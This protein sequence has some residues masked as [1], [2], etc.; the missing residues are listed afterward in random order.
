MEP[1]RPTLYYCPLEAYKERYTMQLSAPEWGW[2]ERNWKACGIPYVRVEGDRPHEPQNIN[3]GVALDAVGR[4]KMCFA[5]VTKLLELLPGMK[6]DDVI[7]FDDF[8]HPGMEAIAYAAQVMGRPVPKMYANLW[9]QSVD[10]FDFTYP[11]RQWMRHY[12]RGNAAVLSG[13]FVACPSLKDKVVFGGIAG[14]DDVHA[15]GHPF[16]SDE[17]KSRMTFDAPREDKVVFSSRWDAEKNPLFFLCVVDEVLRRRPNTRFVVCSSHRTLRSNR[18]HLLRHLQRAIAKHKGKLLLK[19]GLTKEQYYA[20]LTTAKIQ[21]NTADQ[22]WISYVLLE[23]SCAGCYP[24][25]PYFRSFPEVFDFGPEYMYQRLHTD[26][27]ADMVCGVLDSDV[28]LWTDGAISGRAWIHERFDST[29]ER[30]AIIMG[31]IEGEVN[32]PF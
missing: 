20:E 11:M 6:F 22:D 14:P 12:E 2:L 30:M 28:D 16:S 4:T 31:L 32:E 23:A 21:I 19:E 13:I 26:N 10:E 18:E 27:A 3:T 8:W 24:V 7:Y 5:Q 9:A 25:Y 15:V 1:Q 17:V 29:W